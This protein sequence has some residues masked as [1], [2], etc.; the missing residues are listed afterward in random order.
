M[1]PSTTNAGS[2]ADSPSERSP[3][4][5]RWKAFTTVDDR[6]EATTSVGS[7]SR[8]RRQ[9]GDG[10]GD[11]EEYDPVGSA[12]KNRKRKVSFRINTQ[13]TRVVYQMKK[14]GIGH[15]FLDETVYK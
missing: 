1:Y 5:N 8:R 6:G 2:S 10:D 15:K 4:E 14:T 9:Q 12:S 13:C 7:S 3:G 11:D